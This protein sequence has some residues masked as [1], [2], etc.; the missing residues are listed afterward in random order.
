MH[1][2]LD[3]TTARRAA[4][5]LAESDPALAA[6]IARY[7]L[8]DIRPHR[9][10]YQALVGEIIG[11][12]LSVKA[13]AA[14]RKRFEDLF[15]GEFPEPASILERSVDELKSVGLSRPKANYICDLAQHI[16]DGRVKFGHFD[17]LGNDEIIAELREVKGIGEW[18]AHMFLMFCMG[19]ADVLASGDLGIRNAVQK[20]YNL[21]SVPSPDQVKHV[22]TKNHWH[23]YETIACWYLWRSLE[24]TPN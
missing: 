8:C 24:N 19:R 15:G 14:I 3:E 13:A 22:A 20:L 23:P 2:I 5:H 4:E 16:V 21:K 1:T 10:Y 12:Q 6:V 11:Q 17:D 18:T 9:N 7:G